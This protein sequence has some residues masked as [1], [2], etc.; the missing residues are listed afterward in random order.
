MECKR[1]RYPVAKFGEG[2]AGPR[3]PLSQ[4]VG[5]VGMI[6]VQPPYDLHLGHDFFSDH[7]RARLEELEGDPDLFAEHY[8]PCCKL[9]SRARGRPITLPDG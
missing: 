2:F 9:F 6:E 1:R 4:A 5:Q 7:G 8:A 3:A